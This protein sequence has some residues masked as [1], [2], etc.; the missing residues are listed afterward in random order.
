MTPIEQLAWDYSW[1]EVEAEG[2]EAHLE[3]LLRSYSREGA[4]LEERIE[5][6]RV[7][8]QSEC[9]DYL[10]FQLTKHGLDPTWASDLDWLPPHYL[11]T[12]SLARWKY[13]IWSGVRQ[14]AMECLRSRF[15]LKQT[16][17]A[18][19][20]TLASPTRLGFAH[21]GSFDGFLPRTDAPHSLI[22]EVFVTHASRLGRRYWT[23]APAEQPL[24]SSAS[25]GNAAQ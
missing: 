12:L 25:P 18:I 1:L 23:E 6:W 22:A 8:I 14:G 5:F 10:Q 15:D 16:R 17:N 2:L 11:D 7:L 9:T 20:A 24:I 21:Q 4:L 13:L 3:D 19:A